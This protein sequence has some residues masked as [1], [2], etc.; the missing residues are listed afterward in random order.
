VDLFSPG[1]TSTSVLPSPSLPWSSLS[2]ARRLYSYL[3][4]LFSRH[5]TDDYATGILLFVNQYSGAQ[6]PWVQHSIDPSWEKGPVRNAKEFASM[7]TNCGGCI[8]KCL[9]DP[10]CSACISALNSIDTRDQVESYRAVTSFESDLLRDFSFCILEKNNVFG[11]D[12]SVPSLPDVT[13]CR[14]FRGSPITHDIADQILI[15]HLRDPHGFNFDFLLPKADTSWKVAC[16]ANVAYDQF[17]SQNQLFYKGSSKGTDMWYDPVFK[18]RTLD[19]R[20]VW[21]KRHYKV[22][23]VPSHPGRYALSVLDNGVASSERWN[24]VAV[25]DDLSWCVFHYAGAARAVGQSYTGGLLCTRDGELPPREVLHGEIKEAFE[26]VDISLFELF[27]CDNEATEEDE[28]DPPPLDF[29]RNG[30]GGKRVVS[31]ST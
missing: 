11:C 21:C 31:P 2:T 6:V 16:G 23:R 7:I 5:T 15:G 1:T 22:R 25:A 27:V 30:N 3:L 8:A 26:S 28:R 18:V 29:Y 19:G 17:P 20:T 12:A 24:V 9:S 10:T 13:P 14:T 4:K